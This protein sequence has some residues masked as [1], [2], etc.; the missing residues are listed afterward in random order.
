MP[1]WFT[2]GVAVLVAVGLFLIWLTG[3]DWGNGSLRVGIAA[4]V[5]AAI[6]FAVFLIRLRQGYRAT[7]T[8]S[9]GVASVLVLIVIGAA[10]LVLVNPLHSAQGAS[11]AS[12][13]KYAV[14]IHEYQLAGNDEGVARTYN[15]WGEFLLKQG[16]YRVPED[17][18]Q[19]AT[20]GAVAKFE[21][22]LRT[23]PQASY[24]QLADE[25]ARAQQGA[26]TAYLD[27]A[28]QEEANSQCRDSTLLEFAIGNFQHAVEFRNTSAAQQAQAELR[29]PQDVTGRVID[30]QKNQ[31]ASNVQL[32]LSSNL[33]DVVNRVAPPS[34]DYS[35]TSDANGRFVFRGVAPSEK[36][37]LISYLD[38]RVGE[39]FPVLRSNGQPANVVQ[40]TPLCPTDAGTIPY[41]LPLA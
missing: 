38:P 6:V 26:A 10:G 7:R 39:T 3:S 19:K 22:V 28:K 33:E 34:D 27:L 30:I 1:I 35:A 41:D 4:L 13:H 40:V 24:P 21:Y 32:F 9:L 5:V 12:Q 23:Y 17:P 16:N 15:D 18:S 36:K 37:Y 11:L 31:L 25:F 29:K 20:D 2:T 8:I 14:A